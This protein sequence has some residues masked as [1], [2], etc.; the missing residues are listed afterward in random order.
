MIQRAEAR[1][2]SCGLRTHRHDDAGAAQTRHDH[3]TIDQLI[4]CLD[5]LLEQARRIRNRERVE[6]PQPDEAIEVVLR[7]DLD[8]QQA[9]GANPRGDSDPAI[10]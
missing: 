4:D 7:E 1:A 5:G 2:R 8:V 3:L 10:E 9:E 6:L